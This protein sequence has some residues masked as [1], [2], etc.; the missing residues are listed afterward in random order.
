VFDHGPKEFPLVTLLPREPRVRAAVMFGNLRRWL[1]E[2]WLWLRPRSLPVLFAAAG[3]VAATISWDALPHQPAK[4]P[5][6]HVQV[7]VHVVR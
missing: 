1:L 5:L 3:A 6:H 2:R 7:T 4:P